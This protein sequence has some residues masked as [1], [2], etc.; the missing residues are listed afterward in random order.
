MLHF[1]KNQQ[2]L[3]YG[4]HSR[5][6]SLGGT[7]WC[8]ISP[9]IVCTMFLILRFLSKT[10]TRSCFIWTSN[11]NLWKN[12]SPCIYCLS[13]RNAKY[14]RINL[15]QL[16]HIFNKQYISMFDIYYVIQFFNFETKL[17]DC[18]YPLLLRWTETPLCF[19][20]RNVASIT[21]TSAI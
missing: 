13:I 7:Q 16:T 3:C 2:L 18:F 8:T 1:W 10:M 14:N 12:P 11:F 15:L 17:P 9:N 5:G 20:F 4:R 19:S 6:F 21:M